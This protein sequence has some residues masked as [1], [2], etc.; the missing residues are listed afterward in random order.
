MD[1]IKKV[2]EHPR[3]ILRQV[4]DAMNGRHNHL[5]ASVSAQTTWRCA[6]RAAEASL[7]S[8]DEPM[9][10]MPPTP[11][12]NPRRLRELA[13]QNARNLEHGERRGPGLPIRTSVNLSGAAQ[14]PLL[15]DAA[16]ERFKKT[17]QWVAE[18]EAYQPYVRIQAGKAEG[19]L[20]LVSA[21]LVLR[22]LDGSTTDPICELPSVEMIWDTGAHRTIITEDV[23]PERFQEHLKES[24]HDRYRSRDA[25]C[26]QLAGTVALSNCPVAISAVALVV[27]KSVVPNQRSGILFGQSQCIDRLSYRAIPR[28][29]LQAKGEDINE[30]TWGDIV[31]EEYLGDSGIVSL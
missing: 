24:I 21:N 1:T 29:I 31:V 9:I 27:P 14:P 12:S 2:N 25:M 19:H 11:A 17:A 28:R 4:A 20:P 15:S 8:V 22:G 16:R 5:T 23:L 30:E 10:V 6:I 13:V 18:Q 26:V 7:G 3:E